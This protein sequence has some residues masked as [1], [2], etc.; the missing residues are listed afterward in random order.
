MSRI[1]LYYKREAEGDRWLVGDRYI[2]HL[3]RRLVRGKSR[4]SGIE[5]VFA[6]LC[7]GLDKL[8][9]KYYINLPFNQL[10]ESDFVGVLGAGKGCL[11]GYRKSNSI[12]AGIGLMTHP[13]EWS[14][15]CKDY[16]IVKYLQH[17]EWAN[18]IYKPYFGDRCQIWAV[19]IDTETWQNQQ[20]IMKTTDF[21]IYD[22]IMWNYDI[23]SKQILR[24]IR[25]LL[26]DKGL[27][28]KELRY[29]SYNPQDYKNI[30]S[31]C[32][33]MIFLCE[34]ESQGLAYQECL[35]SD[36][37]ILAWDQGEYLDP[38]R[39][40]WGDPYIRATSVPYWSNRCGIKFQNINEFPNKLEEFLDN[41]SSQYF[42]PRDYILNNLTL[43]KCAKNYLDILLNI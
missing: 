9:I 15:L 19:G 3:A 10:H 25:E 21:L 32:R 11:N 27:T 6:N 30:L 29:G 5:K 12:V 33:S 36:V 35:S 20:T 22:K 39:F 14:T 17:S 7:L 42:A 28:F 26:N 16:P 13:S 38:N 2:R 31:S 24:P 1:C 18:N 23:K 34:H 8:G 43:E 4:L 41:L 40:K 37:P